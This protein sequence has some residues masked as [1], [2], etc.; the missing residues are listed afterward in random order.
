MPIDPTYQNQ[1]AYDQIAGRLIEKCNGI[2]FEFAR[3]SLAAMNDYIALF[4]EFY[5]RKR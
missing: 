4:T 2:T 5:P 1:S 3:P